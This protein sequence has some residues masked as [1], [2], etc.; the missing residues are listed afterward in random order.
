MNEEKNNKSQR[1]KWQI[2]EY[3]SPQ[4]SKNWY[5]TALIFLTL[6]IF[7]SLFEITGWKLVFLG[8]D[9]NF[10]FIII[11][12]MSAVIMYIYEKKPPLMINIKLDQEGVTV[13]QKFYDYSEF[14]NFCV[15][16]RPKQ[17]LKRLYL[18]FKNSA[19]MRI[20]LPLR[21]LDA[22]SVRNFLARYLEEDFERENAPLSEQ[23]TKI[24]KL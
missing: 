7:F 22:L 6:A 23:L 13:G 16:Y 3:R 4:R 20:S 1:I 5:I 18:E 15:L 8:K 11:L 2:P 19:K 10:L 24:L 17:S 12:L 14:K 9:S 21:S